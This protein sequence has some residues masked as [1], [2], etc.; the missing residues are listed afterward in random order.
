MSAGPYTTCALKDNG[1]VSCWGRNSWGEVGN[2]DSATYAT[3]AKPVEGTAPGGI[4]VA[5]GMEHSCAVE[6]DGTVKCWGRN[7]YAQLGHGLVG[8]YTLPPGTVS[9]L[10]S[11]V[12]SVISGAEHTCALSDAGE[13]YCWGRNTYGQIGNGA[14]G[15]RVAAPNLVGGLSSDIVA[16]SAGSDHTCA[17]TDLGGVKC[18][19]RNDYGEI[20]NGTTGGNVLTPTDVTGLS[21]G[22]V[23]IDAGPGVTCAIMSTGNVKCWGYNKGTTPSDVL[24]LPAGVTDISVALSHFCAVLTDGGAVCWGSNQFGQIGNGSTG[25]NVSTPTAVVGLSADVTA[26]AAGRNH[27]CALSVDGAVT[28]WGWNYMGQLGN[29]LLGDFYPGPTAF[30]EVIGL[31]TGAKLSA[32][33]YHTCALTTAGET[34]C[35]GYNYRLQATGKDLTEPSPVSVVGF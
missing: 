1:R 12:T 29:G 24:G 31:S 14:T 17:L 28:C 16:I 34:K 5:T 8:E 11:G 35:W 13:V 9:G 33:N 23:A 6:G 27:T 18:W 32:G 22:V 19:G 2:D 26:I 7:N 20:G 30:A 21:A 15:N 4:S 3:T 25:G 10:P